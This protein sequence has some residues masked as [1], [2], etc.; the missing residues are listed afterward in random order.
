MRYFGVAGSGA[1]RE[2]STMTDKRKRAAPTID[3]TAT[4]VPPEAAPAQRQASAPPQPPRAQEPPQ[5]PPGE[6]PAAEHEPT[7]HPHYFWTYV[8][9]IAAGFAGAIIA[10]A[11]IWVS[12]LWPAGSNNGGEI[13][14]MQKQ[15]H[16]LQNR[17]APASDMQAIDALRQRVIKIE[18]DIANL[19]PGDKTV[20]ERLAAADNAMKSLGIALAAINKR[21]DDAASDAKQ[22]RERAAA[23]E[24]AVGELRDSVQNAKPQA[25]V[26]AGQLAAVQ[27]RVGALEQAMKDARAQLAKTATIDSAARLALSAAALRDA[28]EPGAPYAA[29]LAQTK[30]LGADAQALAP[31]EPFAASGVPGKAALAQQL[32]ALVPALIKAAGVRNTPSGFLERLQANASKL[33]RISP[34]DAPSGD[35]PPDILARIEVAAAHADI[36]AALAELAKLSDA[37]RAPAVDWIAKAKARQA[38]LAAARKLAADSARALGK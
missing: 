34:V 12:G 11:V 9:P 28:V 36:A 17:P 7:P 5:A 13:A 30:A 16:D 3:L 1:I 19:P 6:P 35:K 37:A 20:A 22:A 24:K 31:L 38:A 33:V 25:A 18:H 2:N 29:E 26:D 4:E 15:I 23:A 10:G 32:D 27:Q 21:N 14:A 8:T